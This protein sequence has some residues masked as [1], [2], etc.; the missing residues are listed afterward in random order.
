MRPS[1]L[2]SVPDP[3]VQGTETEQ[4]CAFRETYVALDNRIKLLVT[5]PINKLDRLAIKRKV[6]EIGRHGAASKLELP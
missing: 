1:G 5:R 2:R 4:R 6:D 3:G